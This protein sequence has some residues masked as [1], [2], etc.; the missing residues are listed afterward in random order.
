METLNNQREKR[1]WP[2]LLAGSLAGAVLFSLIS[3]T[4]MES[5]LALAL[6]FWLTAMFKRETVFY[7]AKVEYGLA[8]MDFRLGVYY[9][10]S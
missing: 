9:T 10:T 2:T 1:L 7:G 8:Y 6:V 4:L 5:F 3:I